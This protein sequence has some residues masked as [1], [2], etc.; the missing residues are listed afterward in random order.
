MDWADNLMFGG[1]DDW[2]LPST[3]QPDP[4]CDLQT[5]D[6]PPQGFGSNCTG[7]EM[8]HIFYNNLGGIAGQNLTGNQTSIDG[9]EFMN[10]QNVYWSG[11]EFGPDPTFAWAFSFARGGQFGGV[12]DSSRFAA[13]A[14]RAGE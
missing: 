5:V 3:T 13:W 11:T 6:V 4:T 12:K 9:I 10:I 8:G 1:F 7:S 2:R 14:V